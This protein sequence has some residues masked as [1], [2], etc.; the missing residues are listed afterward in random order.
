M[1]VIEMTKR[2]DQAWELR[3]HARAVAMSSGDWIEIDGAQVLLY[4]DA[5]LRIAYQPPIAGSSMPFLLDVWTIGTAKPKSVTRR[6]VTALNAGRP[7][8]MLACLWGVSGAGIEA[9][10]PG[11][12]ERA[13]RAAA[14]AKRFCNATRP[15]SHPAR[16]HFPEHTIP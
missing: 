7:V 14:G 8:K 3:D 11:V 5:S 2:D 16:G 6:C 13:L 15:M 9:Y 10:R 12:W 1:S 4:A